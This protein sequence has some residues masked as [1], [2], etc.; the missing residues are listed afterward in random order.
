MADF[1]RFR[2]HTHGKYAIDLGSELKAL[3]GVDC[4]F[5]GVVRQLADVDIKGRYVTVKSRYIKDLIGSMQTLSLKKDGTHK[6]SYTSLIKTSIL[7][8]RSHSRAEIVIELCKLVERRGKS[9]DKVH[10]SHIKVK[11]L[12]ERCPTLLSRYKNA[13]SNSR[14]N[15]M[16]RDDI[17]E[18]LEMIEKHTTLNQEF[19]DV[20][21]VLPQRQ[22][23][24]MNAVIE[25]RHRGRFEND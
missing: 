7:K 9:E 25:I 21:V 1:K 6:P 11:T 15:N 16:I 23:M 4:V 3:E 5:Q 19:K 20:E 8:E 12:L 14:R 13:H 24:D 18:S 10:T 2:G 17:S 22:D